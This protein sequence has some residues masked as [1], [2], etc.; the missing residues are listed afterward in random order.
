MTVRVPLLACLS[1]LIFAGAFSTVAYAGP[2]AA[3]VR[4]IDITVNDQMKYDVPT[5]TAKRGETLRIRLRATGSMPKNIMAHNFVVLKKIADVNA[6]VTKA[7]VA[8][9]TG[10]MPPD[11]KT[12]VIAASGLIGNGETVEVAFKAPA[13][14]G[15]YPYLCTFPGHYAAGMKGTLIVK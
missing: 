14:A 13:A 12:Q 5:I 10:Y 15:S 7:N 8:R 3:V 11:L 2:P 1:T 6:F 4:T 9:D